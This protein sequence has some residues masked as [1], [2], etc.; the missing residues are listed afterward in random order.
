MKNLFKPLA[1]SILIPLVLTTKAPSSD[2]AIYEKI[3][4]SQTTLI[5]SNK[6]REGIMKMIIPLQE[7]GL[8]KVLAKQ[9]KMN[10][11]KKVDY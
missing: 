7:S 3:Y 4:G 11:N 5:I 6:E 8:K 2:A 10:Q 1:T 9:V